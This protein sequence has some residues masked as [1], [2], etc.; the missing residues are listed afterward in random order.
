MFDVLL[1]FQITALPSNKKM[2]LDHAKI[3]PT[4]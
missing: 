2:S 3:R 1:L 4:R